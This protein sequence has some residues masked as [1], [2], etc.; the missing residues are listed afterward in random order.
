MSKPPISP[1][2]P[3]GKLD[4]KPRIKMT[5]LHA[6][7]KKV[8]EQENPRPETPLEAKCQELMEQDTWKFI[9][10]V[11]RMDKEFEEKIERAAPRVKTASMEKCVE[12]AVK[13][14]ER[15]SQKKS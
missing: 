7:M 11:E 8:A 3:K 6:M 15:L 9:K 12:E 2:R 13:L 4:S 14:L 10:E 5:A 1:G